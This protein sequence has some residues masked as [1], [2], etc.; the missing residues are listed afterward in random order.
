MAITGD[1]CFIVVV[2]TTGS[3]IRG[4]SARRRS[5][6]RS[7]HFKI[8]DFGTS[9]KPIYTTY[10]V[11]FYFAPFLGYCSLL[12]TFLLST[13]GYKLNGPDYIKFVKNISK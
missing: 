9:E 10:Q 12:V 11:A 3:A 7:G 5:S 1:C 2:I 6:R 8:S 4:D 13:G